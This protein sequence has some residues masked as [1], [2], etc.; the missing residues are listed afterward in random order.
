M[1]DLHRDVYVTIAPHLRS[2]F[3]DET[4]KVTDAVLSVVATWLRERALNELHVPETAHSRSMRRLNRAEVLDEAA[5]EISPTH[6]EGQ[7]P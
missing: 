6:D 4:R 2:V 3:A 1:S 7:T 5:D